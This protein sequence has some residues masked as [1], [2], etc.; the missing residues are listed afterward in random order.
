MKLVSS[1]IA[2]GAATPERCCVTKCAL[3]RGPIPP[4][5]PREMFIYFKLLGGWIDVKDKFQ[6]IVKKDDDKPATILQEVGYTDFPFW[7]ELYQ[8]TA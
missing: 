7:N 8:G 2:E 6:V 5:L 4:Y 1:S 3:G